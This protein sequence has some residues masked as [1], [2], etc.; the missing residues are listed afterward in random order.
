R[1]VAD[2]KPDFGAVI[3][4]C[5]LPA[6]RTSLQPQYKQNRPGMPDDMRPQE[7]WLQ[8][9]VPLFGFASLSAPDTEADDLIAS[10][11][12]KASGEGLDV[13]V[14]TNDKDILS[15]ADGRTAI[16]ST[17]KADVGGEGF[18]LLGAAE[19]RKKWGVEPHQIT[20][21][22]ALTGDSSDNIP[23]V[24]GVGG[25]T[26]AALLNQFETLDNLLARLS[27]VQPVRLREKLA[28]ALDLIAVNRQMVALDVDLLLPLPLAELKITPNYD[29]LIAAL[30][31]CEFK[32]LL[33][34]VEEEAAR[35][36]L[37]QGDLL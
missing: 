14:A 26:A 33:K 27:E 7:T 22:L 19:I 25:K 21:V 10:Y 11:A 1:M 23:G 17:A 29:R 13:V 36:Q 37:S 18:A 34:E 3:W 15:L 5:G 9:N 8:K 20:D 31:E 24:A 35:G 30:R 6:R 4:D 2:V 12:R 16:Y 28:S 32:G